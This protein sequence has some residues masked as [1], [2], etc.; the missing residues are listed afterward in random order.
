VEFTHDYVTIYDMHDNSK[1]VVGE[2]NHQSHLYTFSRFIDK[3]DFDLLLTHGDNDIRL[4]HE[5]FGHLNFK[6]MQP[7]NQ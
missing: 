2:V 5:I 6:Y 4:W 1:I 7:L 3:F